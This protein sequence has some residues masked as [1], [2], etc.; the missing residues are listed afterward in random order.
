MLEVVKNILASL[1]ERSRKVY[2]MYVN[3]VHKEILLSAGFVEE[4]YKRKLHYLE[5]S[6]LSN[7]LNDQ[8]EG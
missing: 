7:E 2:I 3:P 6:I 5:L 8:D 4:Y 1:K